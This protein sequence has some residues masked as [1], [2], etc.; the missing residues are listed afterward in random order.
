MAFTGMDVEQVRGLATQ[1]VTKAEEIEQI[2]TALSTSLG[3][4]QWEGSDATAFRSDWES[5]YRTQLANV[6]GAL[7]DAATIAN[8]NASQ[9]ETT[10]S[11]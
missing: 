5:T 4:T 9:Q 2:S 6:A 8:T 7:R 1:L 3:S 10:S 11:V